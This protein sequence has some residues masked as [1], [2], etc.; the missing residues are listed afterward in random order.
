MGKQ[1]P[2]NSWVCQELNVCLEE[3]LEAVK[4]SPT[5]PRHSWSVEGNWQSIYHCKSNQLLSEEDPEITGK[6]HATVTAKFCN[7]PPPS[8]IFQGR[9]AILD[10]MHQY[11][12]NSQDKQH[13]FLLHGLGGAGK[14][15]IAYKFVAQSH[16]LEK[17]AKDKKIGDIPQVVMQWLTSHHDWLLLFNNADDPK[18]NLNKSFIIFPSAIIQA[19]AF[20]SKSGALDSYLEL[21]LKHQKQL[22]SEAPAQLHDDYGWTVYTTWR[23]SFDKLSP[24][25]AMLF[26][27]CSFLHYESI[28]EQLFS[29]ASVYQA[30]SC[31][32]C[33]EELEEPWKFLSQFSGPDDTWD[34]LEF[35]KITNELRAY[36][37]LEFT[38]QTKMFSIHPLV[39][40]WIQSTMADPKSYHSCM[41]AIVG[42]ITTDTD[43]EVTEMAIL[44]SPHIDLLLGD[45]IPVVP[46]FNMEYGL[47]C[48]HSR[49][50]EQAEKLLAAAL[51][52]RKTLFGAMN[53]LAMAYLALGRLKEAEELQVVVVQKGRVIASQFENTPAIQ[54]SLQVITCNLASIYCTMGRLKEASELYVPILQKV[55]EIPGQRQLEGDVMA[56][57]ANTFLGLGQ[58][59]E[60]AKFQT[61]TLELFKDLRGENHPR[62]LIVSRDLGF[63]YAYM[64]HLK[65]AENLE[66]R[67]LEKQKEVLGEH[68]S[69]ITYT[70][71]HLAWIYYKQDRLKE[72]QDLAVT[73]LEQQKQLLGDNH[74]DT[75]TAKSRL[76]Y[77]YTELGQYKDTEELAVSV[78]ETSKQTLGV[79]HPSTLVAMGQLGLVYRELGK[80]TEAENLQSITLEKQGRYFQ[81]II[82][83]SCDTHPNTLRTMKQLKET[84]TKLGKLDKVESLSSLIESSMNQG[85]GL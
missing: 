2:K 18:I 43:P 9:Q 8:R 26:Q 7:C 52:K 80:F 24:T 65:E 70:V 19:G 58:L 54:G 48:H 31:G 77:I 85:K 50:L 45:G 11:F 28:S 16:S 23:I 27:L 12:T 17:I 20:I 33:T 61:D 34:Q 22:L 56:W 76:G 81:K 30:K 64:G 36:S 39:H 53:S 29:K 15:Q 25:A 68:H 44:A 62:T 38:P 63:I 57:L 35:M 41:K 72:A 60:A 13:I 5:T 4:S 75:L 66:V 10:Q 59:K 82:Q 73:V 6:L 55:K 14:T 46:D 78:S 1:A 84:Y 37:L 74:P 32:P 47:L 42:M 79:D 67:V 69:A 71:A 51:A 3:I 49:R 21:Y 83:K 40:H